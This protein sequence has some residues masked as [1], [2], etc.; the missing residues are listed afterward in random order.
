MIRLTDVNGQ[1]MIV[2][3]EQIAIARDSGVSQK[4]HGVR[5]NVQLATDGKW[6][7]AQESV[8]W[9]NEKIEEHARYAAE[10][11]SR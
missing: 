3:P 7:E 11:A 1:T 6:Y 8:D 10:A 5:A 4:W 2:N 9:I